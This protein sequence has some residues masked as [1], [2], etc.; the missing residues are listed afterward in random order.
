MTRI[1]FQF[2]AYTTPLLTIFHGQIKP[3]NHIVVA[4][5]FRVNKEADRDDILPDLK[6]I[7][8][9]ATSPDKFKYST[10]ACDHQMFLHLPNIMRIWVIFC[11]VGKRILK[12]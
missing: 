12:K 7:G 1:F 9:S 8:Y 4:N 5:G 10:S 2:V 11:D 6:N 3:Y